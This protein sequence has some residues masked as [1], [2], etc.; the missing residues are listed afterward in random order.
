[1]FNNLIFKDLYDRFLNNK[2]AHAYLF[3]TNDFNKLHE[4]LHIFIKA[5][6]CE[7]KYKSD[8]SL[9][10]ICNLV[11]KKNLPD[12]VYIEPDGLNIKKQQILD[13][14][15]RFLT[16]SIYAKYSIYIINHCDC[17]N[18]SSANSILKF[19]EE[20]EPNIIGF[21]ITDNSEKVISTVKSR[22]EIVNVLYNE[23][24]KVVEINNTL[25]DDIV[26]YIIVENKEPAFIYKDLLSRNP[27]IERKKLINLFENYI[28]EINNCLIHK[29]NNQYINLLLN[30]IK[31][32]NLIDLFNNALIK[33]NAN[34]N[35][36]MF[37]ICFAVE[38]R[39]MYE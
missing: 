37:I 5:I 10:N 13:L 32:K 27:E 25:I 15:S 16:K 22:C 20:P 34:V 29:S 23:D 30:K 19:L 36:E 7:S 38:L 21:Y 28:Y 6:L 31:N 24:T 33:L 9:C 18:S 3:N 14:K 11:D 39:N 2:L 4:D 8:C 26:R 35:I 17:L 12:I 1:M